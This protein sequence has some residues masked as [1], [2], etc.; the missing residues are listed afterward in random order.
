MQ[1][2]RTD[3]YFHTF[4]LEGGVPQLLNLVVLRENS[5][6]PPLFAGHSGCVED[7]SAPVRPQLRV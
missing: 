5:S 1:S 2:P 3:F 7:L 4:I 6:P